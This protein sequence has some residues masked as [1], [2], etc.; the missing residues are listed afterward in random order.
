MRFCT[1]VAPLLIASGTL[2]AQTPATL[3]SPAAPASTA[4]A[5][6]AE[7]A[8][9]DSL[10]SFMHAMLTGDQ[11]TAFDLITYAK[12]EN[13]KMCE[14]MFGEA[15]AEQR[16]LTAATEQFGKEAASSLGMDQDD[17][18]AIEKNMD[19]A[20]VTIK[21]DSAEVVP[22]PKMPPFVM[23]KKEGKWLVDFEKTQDNMGPP[24]TLAETA[25]S[26]KNTAGYD[27]IT[28][29]LQAKK[30]QNI[31]DVLDAVHAVQVV[32][33]IA[34]AIDQSIRPGK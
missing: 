26:T 14:A 30:Y 24:P 2:L 4:P 12:P 28:A 3:P 29:D 25:D 13:R 34:P 23:V 15:A 27:K 19:K 8:V 10:R 6:V 7:S 22:D 11:K 32:T 18:A 33:T 31:K 20:K 1:A 16:L 5:T 21:G 9:R 17:V